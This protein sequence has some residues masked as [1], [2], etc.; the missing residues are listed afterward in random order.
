MGATRRRWP[1]L[2][3][4]ISILLLG[5]LIVI[6][7]SIELPEKP[8]PRSMEEA[9]TARFERDVKMY[10]RGAT[11]DPVLPIVITPLDGSHAEDVIAE[12]KKRL[13]AGRTIRSITPTYWPLKGYTYTIHF[14]E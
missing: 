4:A 1:V 8:S 6:L 14:E 9:R 13:I 5:V 2:S 3:W 7:T 10:V 11:I 12:G